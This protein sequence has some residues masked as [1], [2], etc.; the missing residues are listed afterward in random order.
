MTELAERPADLNGSSVPG[1]EPTKSTQQRVDDGDLTER[2]GSVRDWL[3][4]PR[5][6]G[7]TRLHTARDVADQ[8]GSI[9]VEYG[10]ARDAAEA[11]HALLRERFAAG[12]AITTFGP[13]SPG[14]AVAQK[15]RGLEA[16]YLAA[17]RRRP[18]GR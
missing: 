10:V 3:A 5:F 4:Q 18:R 16:I 13:Y 11:F 15:R 6:E 1:P 14:Q 7:I 17:G 12:R 9:A 2:V 8:Q